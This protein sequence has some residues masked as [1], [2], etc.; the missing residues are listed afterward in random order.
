M[1]VR[2]GVTERFCR[3]AAAVAERIERRELHVSLMTADGIALRAA[4]ECLACKGLKDL[5]TRRNQSCRS[6]YSLE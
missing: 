6:N 1:V 4:S 5:D 2:R 3:V